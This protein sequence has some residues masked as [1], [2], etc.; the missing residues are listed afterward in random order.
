MAT[1][2]EIKR[3]PRKKLTLTK[4][5]IRDLTMKNDPAR[6]LRAGVRASCSGGCTVPTT[7]TAT[8]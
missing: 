2:D 6:D 5:T 4:E 1:K 8:C 3:K 7:W